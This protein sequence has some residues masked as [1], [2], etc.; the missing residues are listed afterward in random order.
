MNMSRFITRFVIVLL[1]IALGGFFA[2]KFMKSETKKASPEETVS[3]T[4]DGLE[5]TVR[6]SRPF[7]RDRKIFGELVP[8]GKVWRTGA[9]EATTI[10]FDHSVTFGGTPV[11]AGTYTVWTI[12]GPE[13]WSVMLNERM[14][15]WGID[16]DGEAQR[17]PIADV[18]KVEVAVRPVMVPVEQFTITVEDQVQ[19]EL[20]LTWDDI[21][22]GIPLTN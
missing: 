2:F 3:F 17:D 12:P 4:V 22:V 1:V 21:Q 16:L 14:Y 8:Y 7:K 19:P 13:S 6:Y 11:K 18:A 20:T 9:N 5:V 15:G 10:T